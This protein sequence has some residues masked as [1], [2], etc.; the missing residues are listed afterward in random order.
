MKTNVVKKVWLTLLVLIAFVCSMI[1][2]ATISVFA[3]DEPVIGINLNVGQDISVVAN[4]DIKDAYAARSTFS[5]TGK[6]EY[7]DEV[8]GVKDE[9]GIY[10]F[11]YKGLSAQY[12]AKTVNVNVEYQTEAGGD[13]KTYKSIDVSVKGI[14]EQYISGNADTLAINSAAVEALHTLSADI[15]NY[16]KAAEKYLGM[17]DDI[18]EVTGGS[19]VDWD[20]VSDEITYT[21]ADLSWKMG[22]RFDYN[23]Q[24]TAKFVSTESNLTATVNG[25]AAKLEEVSGSEN[26]YRIIYSDFNVLDIEKEYTFEVKSG[27]NSLGTATCSIGALAKNYSQ[28]DLLSSA[29]T[30]GVSV[31]KYAD[32]FNNIAFTSGRYNIESYYTGNASYGGMYSF[33]YDK[34]GTLTDSPVLRV[35]NGAEKNFFYSLNNRDWT[36]KIP[37][38]VEQDGIYELRVLAQNNQVFTFDGK[39]DVAVTQGDATPVYAKNV[40]EDYC[41]PASQWT[42]YKEG[43]NNNFFWTD[44]C[45]CRVELKRGE[46]NI[47]VKHENGNA[48]PNVDYF[49]VKGLKENTEITL[50]NTRK[51]F[52]NNAV[53]YTELTTDSST[54]VRV[55]NGIALKDLYRYEGYYINNITGIYMS[56]PDFK[57]K[58]NNNVY[59]QA[60]KVP[61]TE[62]MISGL[63]YNKTGLQT[64]TATYTNDVGTWSANF[65]VNVTKSG[66]QTAVDTIYTIAD[67]GTETE[68]KPSGSWATSTM[69]MATSETDKICQGLSGGFGNI[70]DGLSKANFGFKMK[71]TVASAGSYDL[72]ARVLTMNT[73][74]LNDKFA[75]C[76]S[77]T[78]TESDYTTVMDSNAAAASNQRRYDTDSPYASTQDARNMFDFAYIKVATLTLAEGDNYVRLKCTN[79]SNLPAFDSFFITTA[80][81]TFD[82]VVLNQREIGTDGTA[83]VN[84]S[85][86]DVLSEKDVITL[87]AGV[88]L[89]DAYNPDVAKNTNTGIYMRVVSGIGY[90]VTDVLIYEEMLTFYS[91]EARTKVVEDYTTVAA[92]TKLYVTATKKT[93]SKT[94]SANFTLLITE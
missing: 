4:A 63:D 55:E 49:Y 25:E 53:E 54:A 94:W 43:W 59:E 10:V 67:D 75:Y 85:Y 58:R 57:Y 48:F 8:A 77:Q 82:S 11:A 42:G 33:Q 27:E 13:W 7:S 87:K 18:G 36:V 41:L 20:E 74:N 14:L 3:E 51:D 29:Y 16:G 47:Y 52:S 60:C 32:A 24:P 22:V 46:N 28:V 76:V 19:S 34:D 71:Y 83:T 84:K 9:S 39:V 79:A 81:Y 35:A 45:I 61:V 31:V 2:V 89:S 65:L 93:S 64:V 50:Y 15:L 56:I 92:G 69:W 30:Y 37:V 26:T 70:V 66:V 23:L 44:A 40:S 72:Y 17:T 38:T 90:G 88:R 91:D 62:D 1:G 73:R 86:E 78:D 21:G 80:D 6:E 12:L 5:W 68:G